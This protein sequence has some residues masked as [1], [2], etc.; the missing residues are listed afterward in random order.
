MAKQQI[1]P[2]NRFL[3]FKIPYTPQ[4][5]G[6]FKKI[7]TILNE[8]AKES[9]LNYMAKYSYSGYALK[10]D[11]PIYSK[12]LKKQ[13][14]FVYD[15]Y[16]T[17]FLANFGDLGVQRSNYHYTYPLI[18]N[19]TVD[20]TPIEDI[21]SSNKYVE[22]IFFLET[23]DPITYDSFIAEV[24]QKVNATFNTDYSPHD[25]SLTDTLELLE[26]FFN[27]DPNLTAVI[28]YLELFILISLV[29]YFVLHKRLITIY[30]LNGLSLWYLFKNLAWQ[31]LTVILSAYLINDL[32]SYILYS[33]SPNWLTQIIQ[34]GIAILLAFATISIMYVT[35]LNINLEKNFEKLTFGIMCTVKLL[36]LTILITSLSPLGNLI[37]NGYSNLDKSNSNLH[38]FAMFYPAVIG[39]NSPTSTDYIAENKIFSE[40]D[41]QN[42]IFFD[43]GVSSYIQP[44]TTDQAERNIIVNYN[45]LI[46]TP[47]KDI[48]NNAIRLDPLNKKLTLI[49]PITLKVLTPKAIAYHQKNSDQAQKYGVDVIY[50]EPKYN[51]NFKDPLTGRKISN[52]IIQVV[53]PS[54][55]QQDLYNILDDKPNGLY[56]SIPDSLTSLKRSWYPRMKE[57]HLSDNFPQL[58][59]GDQ[60]SQEKLRLY[61]GN[62]F[63]QLTMQLTLLGAMITVSFYSLLSFFKKNIYSIGVK[64]AFGYS[65]FKNYRTYWLLMGLQYSVAGILSTRSTVG[66]LTYL[67][68]VAVFATIEILIMNRII[69]Y[70]E[71][72]AVK[73]VK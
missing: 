8:T 29:L 58:I 26:P 55:I 25:Y 11:K 28:N 37:L 60:L 66:F 16:K 73:Y 67:I 71:R 40:A 70:L 50:S 31:P 9:N 43:N 6:E 21:F 1:D 48:H 49:I 56:L 64:N 34:F 30:K 57:L 20:V 65:R 52:E 62:F 45:Y 7:I 44:P 46:R 72:N 14:F 41:K 24:D 61:L 10:D 36:L 69:S 39:S 38:D 15:I 47:L 32:L 17:N 54:F 12:E 42:G 19:Y 13:H 68:L 2:S 3:A 35:S 59:R 23:L 63:A 53:N 51:Q 33:L 18:K 27:D 22:C 4:N 5:K